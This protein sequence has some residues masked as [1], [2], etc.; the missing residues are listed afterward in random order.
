[1]A[2][3]IVGNRVQELRLGAPKYTQQALADR[4]GVTR[5]TIISIESRKYTPSLELAPRISRLFGKSVEEVFS[6]LEE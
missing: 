1:M 6:L 5:Q 2:M 3:S 4:L